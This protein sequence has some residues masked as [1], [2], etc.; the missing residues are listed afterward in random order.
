MTGKRTQTLA[1][2][3]PDVANPFFAEVARSVEDRGRALGL[4][5]SC[6]ART[7]RMT[8]WRATSPSSSKSASMASSSAREWKI[9]ACWQS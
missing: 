7:T 4:R 1:L 9:C 3:V 6:A 2:L 5:S 8:A